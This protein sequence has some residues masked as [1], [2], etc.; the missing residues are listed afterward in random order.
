MCGERGIGESMILMHLSP[1][2]WIFWMCMGHTGVLCMCVVDGNK[3]EINN[4]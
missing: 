2:F 4:V 3:I 1:N